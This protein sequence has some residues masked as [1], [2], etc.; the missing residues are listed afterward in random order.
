M[1]LLMFDSSLFVRRQDNNREKKTYLVYEGQG[2]VFRK[3]I[4]PDLYEFLL[5][6][7]K[8]DILNSVVGNQTADDIDFH[9]MENK[10]YGQWLPETL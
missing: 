4:V 9:S 6:N 3:V 8:E 2:I 5:M 7:T 10:C 1:R